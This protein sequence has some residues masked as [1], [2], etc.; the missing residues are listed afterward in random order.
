ME[1]TFWKI[2][3]VIIGLFVTYLGFIRDDKKNIDQKL[4]TK[5][6]ET[7]FKNHEDSQRVEIQRIYDKI[8]TKASETT[9]CR[10]E[11]RIMKAISEQNELLRQILN[12]K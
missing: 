4:D 5:L 12:Q 1:D 3:T 6:D 2:A 7:V 10:M 8:D 9:V 11:D